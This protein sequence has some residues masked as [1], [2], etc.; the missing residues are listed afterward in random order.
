MYYLPP[1]PT[2]STQAVNDRSTYCRCTGLCGSCVVQTCYER[3]PSIEDI[4]SKLFPRYP[5]SQKVHAYNGI[6]YLTVSI[7]REPIAN[8]P[9]HINDT[10]DLCIPMPERGILGTSGR[11]CDPLSSGSDSCGT[12]CCN[13]YE[14]HRYQVQHQECKFVWCC[15][16]ECINTDIIQVAKYRCL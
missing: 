10:P 7:L 3:A 15:R 8:F 11:E 12:L 6:L 14:Q 4:G 9:C 16:I 2:L 1:T 5:G 13:G